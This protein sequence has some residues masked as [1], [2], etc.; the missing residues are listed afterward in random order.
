MEKRAFTA[1]VHGL[2]QGVAFRHYTRATA[3]RL[4]LSGFVRNLPNGSVEIEAEGPA[5]PLRELA[6]WIHHGPDYARV[7]RVDMEWHDPRG[8]SGPFTVRY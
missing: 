2:V 6:E 8:Q 4:N 7:E 3:A 5:G 1:I